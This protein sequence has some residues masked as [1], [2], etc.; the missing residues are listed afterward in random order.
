MMISNQNVSIE[1]SSF[2]TWGSQE[3]NPISITF[4]SNTGFQL[5]DT[6]HYGVP[7]GGMS[8]TG[9]WPY[10]GY[11]G[12]GYAPTTSS[13]DAKFLPNGNSIIAW[14]V[15]GGNSW[16]TSYGKSYYQVFDSTGTP[17]AV[18][19]LLTN[20]MGAYMGYSVS[21]NTDDIGNY[22]VITSS[23]DISWTSRSSNAI[24]E[25]SPSFTEVTAI[26]SVEDSIT[27]ISLNSLLTHSNATDVD[28]TI[29]SYVVKAVSS[30][31]LLIGT[32]VGTAIAWAEGTNDVI[33]VTHFAYWT[34]EA[35]AN[36]SLNAFTVVAKDNGGLESATAIQATV[37]VTAVNDAPTG[38]VTITSPMFQTNIIDLEFEGVDGANTFGDGITTIGSP[39]ITTSQYALGASS[40]YFAGDGSA[41]KINHNGLNIG[42]S[43]FVIDFYFKTDGGQ[44][45]WSVLL[46]S[47][48]Q[49]VWGEISNGN[50]QASGRI[51]FYKYGGSVVGTNFNDGNWHHLIAGQTGEQAYLSVDNVLQGQFTST[52]TSHNFDNLLLG[53]LGGMWIQNSDNSFKGWIDALKIYL[54]SQQSPQQ[55]QTLTASNNLADTDGLGAISYQ[56]QADGTNIS[57]ATGSTFVLGQAQVGK[58]ITVVASYTDG[59]GTAE[60]VSSIATAKVANIND[61][62]TFTS[63]TDNFTG[64]EDT[65]VTFSFEDIKNNSNATDIDGD[66]TAF[67]VKSVVSGTLKIGLSADT[68]TDWMVG[69]NDTINTVHF[70]YWTPSENANGILNA[71]TVVAKDNDGLESATPVQAVINL[72]PLNDDPTGAVNISGSAIQGKIL[73]ASNDFQDVDGLG[74]IS[75]QWLRDGHNILNAT[76]STYTLYSGDVGKSI[77]VKASYRDLAGT[78]ES[79]VSAATALVAVSLVGTAKADTLRGDA[80]ND[81]LDGGAGVDTLIGGLGDDTY[82]I[83]NTLDVVRENQAEGI[84]TVQSSVTYTLSENVENLVLIA[85]SSVNGTG[86][87]L[88]NQLMGNSRDNI[89]NGGVGV[90]TLIGG[91][92]NDTYIV[93]NFGDQV[94]ET[95]TVTSDIDA[96]GLD[97]VQVAIESVGSTYIL[98]DFIEKAVL[99]NSVAFNLVGNQLNNTLTGNSAANILDGAGGVDL[100]IGGLGDDSYLVDL[101]AE[102]RLQDSAIEA[103]NAG[104]DT[105]VIDNIND[106]IFET[107]SLNSIVDAGGIDFASVTISTAGGNYVLA[108]FVE[109]AT[110]NNYIIFN[111]TGNAIDNTLIGNI[112]A[113]ILSG[114]AGNDTLT[115]GLGIDSFVVTSGTDTI[116]DLS[117]GRAMDNLQVSS[118]AIANAML[119]AAWIASPKTSNYGHR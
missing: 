55:G 71:F 64:T 5:T 8:G 33:D 86:N 51:G 47:V 31:T 38:S 60:S 109:N 68:A 70:A 39:T 20:T 56:W 24:V 117:A 95:I 63:F 62:P 107:T 7:S 73:T 19:V 84:D 102:G 66:V 98:G 111:L 29:A 44:N 82:V 57:G 104:I 92:G 15:A 74:A 35:N 108:E 26:E 78:D 97:L 89:L 53:K 1:V 2:A 45:P 4:Y 22:N 65:Q 83:D 96:G 3:H 52:A 110:L 106:L 116:T 80:G 6:Y 46:S 77:S 37:S 34:P 28:G 76:S 81:T 11:G 13:V 58:A 118:G 17:I 32:S 14:S 115:G 79:L 103:A 91:A 49:G 90:D 18:P 119:K 69:S 72:T 93:D 101:T 54:P 85:N 23:L 113:N 94:Y 99:I 16:A 9:T 112:C 100:L 87:S 75:Y 27:T 30:G 59:Y 114:G 88:N 43:D 41:L 21:I 105:Y 42:T 61:A 40:V 36:G 25:Y 50:G 48:E 12:S 10:N 67:V